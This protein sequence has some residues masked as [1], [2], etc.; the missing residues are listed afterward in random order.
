MLLSLRRPWL[1]FFIMPFSDDSRV[2][3]T[4]LPS[5]R[6]TFCQSDPCSA[7][8]PVTSTNRLHHI[9]FIRACPL[10]WG[11]GWPMT[12]RRKPATHSYYSRNNKSA[13]YYG[14]PGDDSP[15][16]PGGTNDYRKPNWTTGSEPVPSGGKH[17]KQETAPNSLPDWLE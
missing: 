13:Y 7:L 11:C 14:L 17:R 16:R 10:A 1:K 6:H 9:V 4:L 2:Y 3:T 12:Q 15:R 5:S 8:L